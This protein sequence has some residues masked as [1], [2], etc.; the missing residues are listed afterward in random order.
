MKKL[1][2]L[3]LVVNILV[4]TQIFYSQ[5]VDRLYLSTASTGRVYDITSLS[6]TPATAIDLPTPLTTPNMS[7]S[8]ANISN[9]AVGYDAPAGNPTTLVF[10]HSNNGS[11]NA[12]YRNGT[13]ITPAL[14]LPAAIGGLGTNNVPGSYFGYVY[15]FE[16]LA[17]T[18]YRIYPAPA[19]NLGTITGD[20]D[21]TNGTTFGTDTFFDY[22]NYIY[23]FINNG[24]SRYLYKISIATRVAVKAIPT[25]ITGTAANVTAIHGMAYL[26]GDIYIAT[27]TATPTIEIRRISMKTGASTLVATYTSSS[28]A[29]L[30]LET[31]PYYVPFIFNCGG[32]LVQETS[33]FTAG[34][35]STKTLRLPISAVYGPDANYDIV[36]SGTD[37]T[38]TTT[39]R[40]ITSTT[41]FVDVPITYN[42]TGAN[43]NRTLTIS[44]NG[45]TTG[46]TYNA[47]IE[48]DLDADG[49]PDVLDLDSDNDGILDIFEC[50]ESVVDV[51]YSVANGNTVNFS[52]PAADL[53]FIFD[54]YTLDN[55]FNLNI[56]GVNLSTTKLEFQPDQTDN[57]RFFD[58][59][60]YG[61]GTVPQIYNMTGTAANPLVRI[62]IH[63]N[64]SVS[65]YGSKASGGPL[66]P[67]QLYNGNTF[68]NI[69][70]N[71]T[72]ANT[73]VLSQLVVGPTYITGRGNGV[74]NGFC[75]P[76]NDGISNQFDVDS[77]NDGCADAI[78][79][80]EQVQFNQVHPLV[81]PTTDPNYPF[82]GQIKVTYNG[83]TAAT[84]AQSISTSAAA[85]GVPQLVNNAGNNLN[86]TTNPTNLAGV[87]DNTDIPTPT[88]ADVGQGIGNSQNSGATDVE[89]SRCFRPATSPGV[90]GLPTNHGITALGRAGATNGNWP[91]KITGAYTALDAKTKGF[92]INRMP[93]TQLASITAV[94]GMMVYDTTE[95]CLKIY[96]NSGTW[97]CYN[98]QTC[99]NFNQ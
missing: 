36:V 89:C 64:G 86:A 4:S 38:T 26:N 15:G 91:M 25:A 35:P 49:I 80:T 96:D 61:N 94:V 51:T 63:K 13:A 76:D 8:A 22:Q 88:T 6:A 31:V 53:G 69:T 68:N 55:S 73:I 57:V 19:S 16:S 99:D 98:T 97:R 77:D 34:V 1:N 65:M 39:T 87:A 83:V 3:L 9:L 11:G 29:N 47:I 27:T 56:N 70:W 2:L 17:K 85:N 46:C 12:V 66:F 10:M 18:L 40:T 71:R 20:T 52:A 84:P 72:G 62:I 32:A 90:G 81:L 28:N 60:T 44:I 37:F 21:W 48:R 14:N 79:G 78:E 58:G 74:K 30:D 23:T 54:V 50:P 43:G 82:R 59:A 45:S 33:P 67:L 7:A 5:A 24:G 41:T 95:N 75:D 42:G 92:V 93:T